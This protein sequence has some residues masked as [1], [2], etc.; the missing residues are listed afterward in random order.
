MDVAGLEEKGFVFAGG[1]DLAGQVVRELGEEDRV[2]E[3]LEQDGREIEIAVET[4]VVAFEIF[5]DPEEG[6][7]GFG[8][9]FVEPLE[10]MGPRAVIDDIGKMRMQGKGEKPCGA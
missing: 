5:E 7:V 4:D 2:R 9:G 3:L 10:S 1:Y 6:E 8:G